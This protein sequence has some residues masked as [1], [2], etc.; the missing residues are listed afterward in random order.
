MKMKE[1]RDFWDWW[2]D[3]A[4]I[5]FGCCITAFMTI[6]ILINWTIWPDELKVTAAIA[7]LIP[8]HVVGRIHEK[9]VRRT[10]REIE[11]GIIA[12]WNPRIRN[13]YVL[14]FVQHLT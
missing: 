4:W 8:I 3:R 12:A 14:K 2:C 1:K 13:E 10:C 11:T 9:I 6:L 7:A 5:M